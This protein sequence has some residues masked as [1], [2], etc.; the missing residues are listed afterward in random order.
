MVAYVEKGEKERTKNI[1]SLTMQHQLSRIVLKIKKIIKC[2]C[3]NVTSPFAFCRCAKI[4]DIKM[5]EIRRKKKRPKLLWH[6]R[7]GATMPHILNHSLNN[8]TYTHISF[9]FTFRH[10]FLKPNRN[11]NH[12][13]LLQLPIH[14]SMDLIY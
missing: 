10:T 9:I 14:K 6:C 8:N 1:Q 12:A 11:Q 4:R 13:Q 3:M 5:K 2:I 7:F